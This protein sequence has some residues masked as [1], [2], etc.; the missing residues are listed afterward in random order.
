[1]TRI[2]LLLILIGLIYIVA[3]RVLGPLLNKQ[4]QAEIKQQEAEKSDENLGENPVENPVENIVLCTRCGLH[5]PES[6]SQLV[7]QQVI[8]NNPACQ[9]APSQ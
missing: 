4:L 1:M 5:V 2:L 9:S 6:E 3:K 7:D 8:C